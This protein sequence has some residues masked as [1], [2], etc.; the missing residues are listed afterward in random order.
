MYKD[1]TPKAPSTAC[2]AGSSQGR[3]EPLPRLGIP[4]WTLDIQLG[5]VCSGNGIPV[6]QKIPHATCGGPCSTLSAHGAGAEARGGSAL[7]VVLWTVGLL[8]ML[9][10]SFAFDA[11]IESRITSYYR[12][13]TKAAYLS[14]SGLE[15]AEMLMQGSSEMSKDQEKTDDFEDDDWFD[16]KKKLS[17]GLAI[18]GMAHELGDGTVTLDI[19]PE[20]A[21]R[22]VN[23]LKEDDWERIFEVAGIPEDLWPELIESFFDWTDED[24]TPRMD[25]AE[26]EDYYETLEDPYRADNGP[27]DTVEELLLVKGFTQTILS[28]GSIQ[29]QEGADPIPISGIG[30]IL[31]TYG[32]GKVN[33][34]A[35]STRVLMTLPEVDEL[36]AGAIIEEREG[37]L[38]DEG[39]QDDT[40]FRDVGDFMGR[41]P[42]VNPSLNQ[43]I[44]IDSQIY[45]I[46]S[47]GT[48]HGVTREIWCIA[49]YENKNLTI[50]RWREED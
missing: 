9:V 30:D 35:A 27:L 42:G 10:A 48:V 5:V 28:G 15:M 50:L 43:Y 6:L 16:D 1:W 29:L 20:P 11:H 24:D 21:R 22:N 17:R 3:H 38:G 32:D 34:N 33:V 36:V 37:W 23:M 2:M 47:V 12:K 49:R 4:C 19:V 31:T 8:S 14:R 45:R 7:I 39:E 26:S 44:S 41:I 46:R 13:R 18:R 25:G 40:S